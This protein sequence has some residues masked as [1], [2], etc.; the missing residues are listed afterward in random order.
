MVPFAFGYA[1]WLAKWA[2][3]CLALV[4]F[5]FGIPGLSKDLGNKGRFKNK[6]K[7]LYTCTSL[8]SYLKVL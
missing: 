3:F 7:D 2:F 5:F 8:Y 1:A 6:T 4:S